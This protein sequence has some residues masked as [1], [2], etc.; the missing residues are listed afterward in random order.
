MTCYRERGGVRTGGG[1]GSRRGCGLLQGTQGEGGRAVTC[2]SCSDSLGEG[3]VNSRAMSST[4][5]HMDCST[6]ELPEDTAS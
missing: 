5:L 6:A 4:A 2:C 3:E 1:G